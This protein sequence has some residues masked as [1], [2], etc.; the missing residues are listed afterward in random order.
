MSKIKK[1]AKETIE[2][3]LKQD[4]IFEKIIR[5][6]G[7]MFLL[8]LIAFLGGWFAL[9][10]ILDLDILSLGASTLTVTIFLGIN[11]AF[12]FGLAS[13]VKENREQKKKFYIDWLIAEFLFSMIAIFA[14]SVYQW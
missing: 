9:D 11:S 6:S 14:I 1:K 13:K 4:I 7:W 2:N 5:F 12:S 10:I 8:S 3:S